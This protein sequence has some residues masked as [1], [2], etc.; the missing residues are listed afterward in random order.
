MD[1]ILKVLTN[2]EKEFIKHHGIRC[3]TTKRR[4]KAV[5]SY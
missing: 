4:N 5:A 2:D 1:D 3:I